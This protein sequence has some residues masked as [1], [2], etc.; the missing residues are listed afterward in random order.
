MD[1][2]SD[3]HFFFRF[4]AS[5]HRSEEA[6]ERTDGGSAEPAQAREHEQQP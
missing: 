6:E 1:R 5:R 3:L 2:E 4:S